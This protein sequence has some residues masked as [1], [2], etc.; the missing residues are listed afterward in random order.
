MIGWMHREEAFWTG[1]GRRPGTDTSSLIR[2]GI[3]ELLVR[4]WNGYVYQHE[5]NMP[6][7][8]MGEKR[9]ALERLQALEGME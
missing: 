8:A 5:Y 2:R 1:Y 3:Y 7:K 6:E 4:L 9:R